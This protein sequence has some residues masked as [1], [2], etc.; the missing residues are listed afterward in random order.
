[1]YSTD[2]NA[3]DTIVLTL[4]QL[5]LIRITH[6]AFIHYILTLLPHMK[7]TVDTHASGTNPTA[8]QLTLVQ[9]TIMQLTFF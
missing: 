4:M 9:R 1:M 3:T 7:L 6:T 2:T 8:T 5:I